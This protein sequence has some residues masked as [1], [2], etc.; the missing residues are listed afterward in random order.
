MVY[1]LKEGVSYEGHL[2]TL[3][4]QCSPILI[5]QKRVF[6]ADFFTAEHSESTDKLEYAVLCGQSVNKGLKFHL[7]WYFGWPDDRD[8][9]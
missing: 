6:Q 4:L 5:H 3:C 1:T 2:L 7:R 9:T 8:G